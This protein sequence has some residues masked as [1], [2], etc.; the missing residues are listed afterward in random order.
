MQSNSAPGADYQARYQ[1][2]AALMERMCGLIEG[3]GPDPT[4]AA[5]LRDLATTAREEMHPLTK[6]IAEQ[7]RQPNNTTTAPHQNPESSPTLSDCGVC[8]VPVRPNEDMYRAIRDRFRA[9]GG[10][11][12][13][14]SFFET[15]WSAML[16]AGRFYD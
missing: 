12:Y 6:E 11:P 13:P 4:R 1:S 14:D 15:I 5:L 7:P 8:R 9:P 16:S 3:E 10:K 2:L